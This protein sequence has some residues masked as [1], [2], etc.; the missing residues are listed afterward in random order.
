MTTCAL[1]QCGKDTELQLKCPVCLKEDKVLVFCDQLC[2]R[3]GWAVH[4]AIHKADDGLDNYNPFPNYLFTGELRPVY[5]L[6]ERRQLPKHI[7]RPDYALDGKPLLEIKNDRLGKIVVHPPKTLEKLRKCCKVAR[8]VLDATAA[9][10]A[11]GITTDELDAI[12]HKECLKRNAYPSPLNYYNF[13][14]LLCTSVNEVICHGIP[15]GYTLQDGDIIN[16]DVTIFYLGVHADLNETYYV[17]DKAKC[18]PDTV[19]LVE[20]TRECL[21]K[22]IAMVKPGVAYRDFGEVIEKHA[23][24]NGCSVV[25]TYCGHGIGELFHSQ[26]NVPHYLKNKA[27][28]ICKPGHVFT[29]E[30]MIC[31]GTWRDQTW[32]DNWTSVTQDGKYSAQ[33]EHQLLVTEDGVE[34]LTARTEK[35]PGGAIPR[36]EAKT[37]N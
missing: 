32:P 10:V 2:F 24:A 21:D 34:V 33:F 3:N 12:L 13:P 30:P 25:R 7:K 1:P 35:S 11:P 37:E 22:A 23:H 9:H 28:G 8:E 20:T 5:P 26:P 31:L 14:K 36:L 27:V 18:D 29:I 4:K 6:L 16:L 15:D 19:R 17:G